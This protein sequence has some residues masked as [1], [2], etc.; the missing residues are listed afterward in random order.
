M[1]SSRQ[2]DSNQLP[3]LL[4]DSFWVV[5]QLLSTRNIAEFLELFFWYFPCYEVMKFN[6]DDERRRVLAEN[7]NAK[8]F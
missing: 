1:T 3:F 8:H 5:N 2:N 7:S 4:F 6:R